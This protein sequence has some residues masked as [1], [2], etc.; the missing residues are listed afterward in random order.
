MHHAQSDPSESNDL[1]LPPPSSPAAR[2]NRERAREMQERLEELESSSSHVYRYVC[3]HF[4]TRT[5][6]V[7]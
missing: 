7:Q 1:L 5:N 4:E 3:L 6:F 2:E